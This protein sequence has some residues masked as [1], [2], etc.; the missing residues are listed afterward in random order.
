[1]VDMMMLGRIANPGEAAASIAAVGITNQVVF[2]A[3]S[4]VQSLNVGATAMVVDMWEQ[5]KKIEL[6]L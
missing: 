5:T 2:I 1:M 3:L 6:N 4:L